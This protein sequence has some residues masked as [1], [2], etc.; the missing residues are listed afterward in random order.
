M[1]KSMRKY[2][3]VIPI[4]ILI[5]NIVTINSKPIP[6]KTL[7]RIIQQGLEAWHYSGRKIDDY[8]SVTGLKEYLSYL[9]Y[10]K[11]YFLQSD[12]NDFKKY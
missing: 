12:I 10:N 9:D 5:I 4:I 2:I 11:R 8:F 6:E 3:V 1:K 7:F